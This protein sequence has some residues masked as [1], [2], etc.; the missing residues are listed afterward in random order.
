MPDAQTETRTLVRDMPDR[1]RIIARLEIRGPD[2]A[3]G[4]SPGFSLTGEVYKPRGTWSG[5]MRHRRGL[6][7]D[8]GGCLH[9]SV[10][11]AFPHLKPFARVHLADLDGSPMHAYAN[12]SWYYP[13]TDIR[14]RF[15]RDRQRILGG[16]WLACAWR[17]CA[18]A[19]R[20]KRSGVYFGELLYESETPDGRRHYAHTWG[21]PDG[22]SARPVF[23]TA[24]LGTVR[25]PLSW[26][27]IAHARAARQLRLDPDELPRRM[28]AQAFINLCI[29]LRE[30]WA[31]D[32]HDARAIFDTIP[33]SN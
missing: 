30:R 18:D 1:S 9:A 6:E 5:A 8:A 12:A 25:G 19:Q 16:H 32:A 2:N 3:R 22:I 28:S 15:L 31:Y 14:S 21:E 29:E 7:W 23:E 20:F 24:G 33:I 11:R 4:L 27:E 13:D 10:L 17:S 26:A